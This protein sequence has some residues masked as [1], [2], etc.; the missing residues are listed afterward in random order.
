MT[1]RSGESIRMVEDVVGCK[2]TVQLLAAIVAGHRRPGRL[3]REVAGISTKVMNERLTKLIRFGLL[4]R[5]ALSE[6]PPQV[7]YHLTTKG[8]QLSE[9]VGEI[10]EFCARWD[11]PGRSS[12]QEAATLA[13][14]RGRAA[15]MATP[16]ARAPRRPV[17]SSV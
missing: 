10:Q 13:L 1:T 8:L 11:V 5:R 9:L 2:W 12:G 14:S 6:K 3:R 15:R 7:E 4:E 16:F 17:P